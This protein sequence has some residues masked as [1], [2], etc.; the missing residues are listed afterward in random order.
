VLWKTL[1]GL[2]LIMEVVIRNIDFESSILSPSSPIFSKK[3]SQLDGGV[4]EE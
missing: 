2:I 1:S 4:N 3:E